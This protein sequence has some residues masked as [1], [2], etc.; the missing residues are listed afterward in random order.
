MAA[1]VERRLGR[2][3]TKPGQVYLRSGSTAL[4]A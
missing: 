4:T 3:V 2:S 1:R